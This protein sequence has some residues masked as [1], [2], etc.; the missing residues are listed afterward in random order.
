MYHILFIH[1]FADGHLGC[2]HALV[3]V[4]SA[5]VNIG[6]HV[7]FWHRVYAVSRYK[8]RIYAGL[9]SSSIFSF[10]RN[11][12]ALLQ[13]GCTHLHLHFFSIDF[14]CPKF[15]KVKIILFSFRIAL[16]NSSM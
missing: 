6:V 3:V 16:S 13:S 14:A 1:S 9:Y 8:P 11:L 4:S 7:C 15:L 5:S 2:F 12:C 10:L